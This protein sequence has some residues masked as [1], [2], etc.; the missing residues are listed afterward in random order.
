ML[1]P[2]VAKK[3]YTYAMTPVRKYVPLR[4][5]QVETKD[6]RLESC[7]SSGGRKSL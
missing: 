5:R 1:S 3:P 7:S 4:E 6:I 2:L